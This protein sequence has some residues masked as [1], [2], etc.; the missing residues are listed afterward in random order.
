MNRITSIKVIHEQGFCHEFELKHEGLTILHGPNGVGKSTVL[1]CL[2][3]ASNNR[4]WDKEGMVTKIQYDKG[5]KVAGSYLFDSRGLPDKPQVVHQISLDDHEGYNRKSGFLQHS[6]SIVL[7]EGMDKISAV[8]NEYQGIP[9][10]KD[11]LSKILAG[12]WQGDVEF[13]DDLV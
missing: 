13:Q 9:L 1:G 4:V 3:Y 6:S 2:N 10:T 8:L 7:E 11:V 12:T 5:F